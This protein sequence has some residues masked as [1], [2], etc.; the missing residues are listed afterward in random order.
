MNKKVKELRWGEN[1]RHDDTDIGRTKLLHIARECF[2]KTGIDKFKMLD[3]SEAASVS[4]R[5]LY[6]YFPKKED[7]LLGVVE[8]ESEELLSQLQRELPRR[9]RFTEYV[10]DSLMY[11]IKNQDKQPC[12]HALSGSRSALVGRLYRSSSLIHRSWRQL[13][14]EPYKKALENGEISQDLNLHSLLS[15]YG[16]LALSYAQ[17]PAEQSDLE[18]RR[19]LEQF[20]I[21]GIKTRD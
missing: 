14:E 21:L 5:T 8:L 6:N 13:L 4:R 19:E 12:F 3:L 15:W 2:C 10:L 16:R 18:L 11:M 7:V 17:Y 20:I 9:R 1:A